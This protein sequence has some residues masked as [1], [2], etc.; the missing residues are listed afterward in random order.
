MFTLNEN[1]ILEKL[2]YIPVGNHN[3]VYIRPYVIS[4]SAEAIGA[5]QDKVASKK[6]GKLAPDD[7]AGVASGIVQYSATA[8]PS[9]INDS[10][11]RERRYIFLLKVNYIDSLGLTNN[12]YIQGYTEYDGI[13]MSGYV[14]PKLKHIVN[15]IIETISI[16]QATPLGIERKERLKAIYNVFSHFNQYEQIFTQRPNDVLETL[17]Q[18][19]TLNILKGTS[20][21]VNYYNTSNT[22]TNFDNKVISSNVN[23]NIT[24]EYLTNLINSGVMSFIDRDMFVVSNDAVNSVDDIKLRVPE[25]SIEDNRFMRFISQREGFKLT[26]NHFRYGTLAAIDPT[27]DNRTLIIKLTKENIDP[28]TAKTPE[29]GEYW[30]GQDPVTLKAYS[31]LE[32]SVSLALKYGFE[33]IYFA[34]TNMNPLNPVTTPDMIVY[35]FNSFINLDDTGLIYLIENFKQRFINEIFLNESNY[36]NNPLNVELY[37]DLINTSKIYLEYAGYP[38]NWYTIP[39]F[40][41]SAFSP[42]LTLDK[43]TLEYTAQ[44][45]SLLINTLTP[46]LS[47][48]HSLNM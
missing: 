43:S 35:N 38:G 18:L 19:E 34:A 27:I 28:F 9:A 37:I 42:V 39:T 10:W 44:N 48:V 12:F 47:K 24:S 20:F 45:T 15:N 7:V 4:P 25:P 30:H 40:A 16:E 36:G 2:I 29:V 23:N 31:L 32:N 22:I 41:N 13:S 8:F 17:E 46:N 5:L 14:D 33:K 3:P 21:D 26:N 1:F 6:G 11:L